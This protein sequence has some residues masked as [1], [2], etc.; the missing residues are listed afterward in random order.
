MNRLQNLKVFALEW[1]DRWIVLVQRYSAAVIVMFV[2]LAGA[3]IWY[4]SGHLGMNTNTKDM[5]SRDLPW[6]KLDLAYEKNFPQYSDT[7]LVVVEAGTPD[8]ALDAANR[9]YPLLLAKKDLFNSVYYPNALTIFRESAL[10]YLSR[11]EL[12]DLAD[13]LAAIQPFLGRLTHDQTL[14]GLFNMLTDAID[15]LDRGDD[16]DLDPLVTQ[17]NLALAATEAQRPYRVSWHRLMGAGVDTE[18]SVYREFIVLQPNLD[19]STLLPGKEAIDWIRNTVRQT[20][21]AAQ[22][23]ADVRLTGS[24]ALDYE[25]LVS[26]TRGTALAMVLA[27]FTVSVIM[28]IGLGS[29]RLVLMSLATLVIGLVLT[30]AFAAVAVGNLNLISIA[31]AVLYIGLG[32]DFAVHFCLRYREL[33]FNGNANA[34]AIRK[35]SVNIGSSL[36]LC[37]STTA[38]GFFAFVPTAYQGVA[39]LGLISGFGMFISL[40]VTLTLLPALLSLLP[41]RVDPR[42]TGI[43]HIRPFMR[44]ML[45]FPFS[46]AWFVRIVS[47]LLAVVLLGLASQLRFDFNLL[48]MQDP[49]NESVQTFQALLKDRD[50]SPWTGLIL[51]SNRDDA[52]RTIAR[53][54]HLPEVDK[55][56]WLE[57]FIPDDQDAKLDIINEMGLLVGDIPAKP[58]VPAISDDERMTALREFTDK[59]S[60]SGAVTRN[61][62]LLALQQNM[63]R[64]TDELA[65]MPTAERGQR[66]AALESSLLASLPGRLQT[67]RASL[68]AHEITLDSLPDA[69]RERWLSPEGRYLVEVYPKENVEDNAALRRFVQAV[70]GADPRVI[71]TPVINLEASDAVVLAFEEA[72]TTALIVIGLLLMVL[73]SRKRDAIYILVPLLMAAV[74]TGG[75]SE[76]FGIPLNFANVIALPLLLGMGVDS[77]IHIIHR[78]RAGEPGDRG[79]LATSSAR[80]VVISALTTIGGMGNL[81]FSSHTG[82][83]SMGKLLTIG[84]TMT[85]LF[86]LVFLPSL[87][88]GT[89]ERSRA[90]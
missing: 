89:P 31:F 18:K 12:Q 3:A 21:I 75:V 52:L 22:T 53:M 40:A 77:G 17:L 61:P 26:V 82:A 8:Q 2:L 11:H 67:L 56:L 79:L 50:T 57:D 1:L 65:A 20:G 88:A 58:Q 9:L 76:L 19:Y 85:L 73:L 23:G 13:N 15:A 7:I 32:V 90:R 72:F 5:L 41:L 16:I 43:S 14:R 80:A 34:D 70:Q 25:E 42:P 6:R 64:F 87:L 28:L 24:V 84:I 78:F 39:E 60:A 71:G 44:R 68:N 33:L 66:L 63:R 30:A 69:L 74:C 10:L 59:L 45:T 62:P 37:A 35:S 46:H 29:L 4:T 38:I 81:A 51:T 86:M 55:T 54:K 83:A 47:I 48:N 36:F 27:F 49:D